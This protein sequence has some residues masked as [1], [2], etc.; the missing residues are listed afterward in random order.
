[1]KY[2]PVFGDQS[3]FDGAS[4]DAVIAIKRP[5]ISGVRSEEI[6]FFSS[7]FDA[8]MKAGSSFNFNNVILKT[9]EYA[10]RRIISEPKRWTWEDKKAGRLPEVGAKYISDDTEFTCHYIDKSGYV[11]G[12]TKND[13]VWCRSVG[14]IIP[15]ETPEEKARREEDEFV[16]EHDE[17]SPGVVCMDSSHRKCYEL[18]KRAAYRKLKGGE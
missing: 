2:E 7:T 12:H 10:E 15:I 5:F 11:W 1:M 18:G 16:G 14:E 9:D 3:L 4:K 13:D 8:V 6:Y 17:S